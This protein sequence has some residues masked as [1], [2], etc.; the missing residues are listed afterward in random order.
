MNIYDVFNQS[1]SYFTGA[2]GEVTDVDP[3]MCR[4]RVT[5]DDDDSVTSDWLPV[6]QPNTIENLDYRLPDIGEDVLCVFLSKEDG[7]IVGSFYAGEVVPPENNL[8]KRTVVF[9]DETRVSYDRKAHTLD[10]VIGNTKIHADQA[11]V[12]VE[13]PQTV[14]LEGEQ[15][16]TGKGGQSVAI[17][18]GQTASMSAGQSIALT[19]PTLTLT[20]GAT[21]MVLNG[22]S[23]QIESNSLTFKGNMTVTGNLTVSGDVSTTGNV[24]ASGV[25]SGSNI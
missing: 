10:I 21:K 9:S 15:T 6:L 16:L 7:Y 12:S 5:F 8:D 17:E 18:A 4:A 25:V 23:A 1:G 3:K 11:S 22:S 14:A 2:I 19:A 20:M 13:A 24:S